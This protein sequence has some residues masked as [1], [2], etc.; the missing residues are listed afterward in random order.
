M[1]LFFIQYYFIH[2]NVNNNLYT[3]EVLQLIAILNLYIC[4]ID[5][6]YFLIIN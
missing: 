4:P 6:F 1:Y 2:K 5:I 3:T